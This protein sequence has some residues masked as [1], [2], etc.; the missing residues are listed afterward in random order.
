MTLRRVEAALIDQGGVSPQEIV[1]TTPEGLPQIVG[2]WVKVVGVSSSDPLGRGMSNTTTDKFWSGELYT[3]VWTAKMMA[4]IK[5]SQKTAPAFEVALRLGAVYVGIEDKLGEALQHYSE[6][7]GIAYQMRDDL[8][9]SGLETRFQE[10]KKN[11][12]DLSLLMTFALNKANSHE[13]QILETYWHN[14][15][16][17]GDTKEKA[18]HILQR[19][20][21]VHE[22]YDLLHHYKNKAISALI[23]LDNANLKMVLHRVVGKIF[24]E[25]NKMDCCNDYKT[26]NASMGKG[27]SESPPS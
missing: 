11:A 3:R 24:Y 6:A 10:K 8:M 20:N 22:I 5:K 12:M 23:P 17:D 16:S 14:P 18:L 1:C 15:N 13:K 4:E 7:L 9:D 27:R 2:P 19:M 21:V 25:V 26:Q